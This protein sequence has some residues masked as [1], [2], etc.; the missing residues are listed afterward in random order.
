MVTLTRIALEKINDG[1]LL[2]RKTTHELLC[3]KNLAGCLTCEIKIL[4]HLSTYK[5]I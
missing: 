4:R 3:L 5:Q 2:M 1:I